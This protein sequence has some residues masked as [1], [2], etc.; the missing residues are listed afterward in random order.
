MCNVNCCCRAES[1]NGLIGLLLI[2]TAINLLLS[3]A[4]IFIRAANT[5][6]YD[7][8][9]IYLEAINNGTFKEVTF[10]DCKKSGYIFKDDYYCKVNGEYLKKPRDSVSNQSLFKNRKTS[11]LV[12]NIIRTVLAVILLVFLYFVISSKGNNIQGMNDEEKKKYSSHLFYL[13]FFTA[14][15]ITYCVLCI[16][17]R[18]L[19]LSVNMDIGFYPDTDQ[20]S[21]E[22]NIAFNYIIDIIEIVLYSI[23]ICFIV[24]IKRIVEK[25]PLPQQTIVIQKH[26]QPLPPVFIQRQVRVQQFISVNS[27][28]P[29][30]NFQ[31][32]Y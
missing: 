24:R 8:A 27:N 1:T 11:E 4:A 31:Y 12:M 15:M 9:L 23:E 22:S 25:P 17:I 7:E 30:D 29:M 14:I 6:R 10:E 13:L 20:N 21:F 2:F 5:K 32:Q 18:A 3:I 16:L 28:Y 19:A 26:P